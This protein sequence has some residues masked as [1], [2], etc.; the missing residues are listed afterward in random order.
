MCYE[1]AANPSLKFV[2]RVTVACRL[3]TN[4][5]VRASQLFEIEE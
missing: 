2:N 1:R 4:E 3:L 5:P